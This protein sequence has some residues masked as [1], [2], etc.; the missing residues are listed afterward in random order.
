LLIGGVVAAVAAAVAAAGGV[1]A[2]RVA[3]PEVVDV[4]ENPRE[5]D[6][7]QYGE[8]RSTSA[9]GAP[10]S[11]EASARAD[12]HAARDS[13]LQA[14]LAGTS[15]TTA[16][17]GPWENGAGTRIG[18]LRE[19]AFAKP[20][21]LSMRVWPAFEWDSQRD[22]Y[23]R[24][25]RELEVTG[26]TVLTVFISDTDGVVGAWA[27]ANAQ[28]AAGADADSKLDESEGR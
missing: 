28:I 17:Q 8:D 12:S 2:D 4:T 13:F 11:E 19:I 23:V 27:D 10:V 18:V 9:P 25:F 5:E 21:D 22:D 3:S 26:M 24:G 6:R 14:V 20:R 15:H 7:A 16:R 1:M